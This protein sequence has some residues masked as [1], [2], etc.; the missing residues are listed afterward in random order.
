MRVCWLWVSATIAT[1]GCG[2]PVRP[3][4]VVVSIEPS[5]AEVPH[6]PP[7]RTSCISTEASE[8]LT[9][10]SPR[11][12]TP[13]RR[14]A[15]GQRARLAALGSLRQGSGLKTSGAAG[16]VG[17][18]LRQA[19]TG[20]A[21]LAQSGFKIP[22]MVELQKLSRAYHDAQK[23]S[24]SLRDKRR[25][26]NETVALLLGA[27]TDWHLEAAGLGGIRG[28][29]DPKT[30]TLSE[31]L[32]ASV[33]DGFTAQQLAELSFPGVAQK[34]WPTLA[35]ARY[36][37][38]DL[39][40]FQKKW[41]QCAGAFDAVASAEPQ[42]ALIAD[43][44]AGAVICYQNVYAVKHKDGSHRQGLRHRIGADYERRPLTDEQQGTVR[45]FARHICQFPPTKGDSEAYEIYTEVKYARAR[46]YLE[47][48]HWQQAAEAFRDVAFNHADMD[49]GIYAARLYL[50]SLLV[51]ATKINSP[52]TSC[53]TTI[54]DDAPKLLE[55]YCEGTRLEENEEQCT[56][57][58]RI[59]SH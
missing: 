44:E 20:K 13:S 18:C 47:A 24:Q 35:Q 21:A 11:Q 56:V 36:A 37:K 26:A 14:L 15:V 38:G 29:G 33:L 10:C 58:K 12:G 53:Q 32:Y 3:N 54:A 46:T 1:A 52:R 16:L 6:D 28:T 5:P 40:H 4:D 31:T 30:L 19:D 7:S 42:G 59:R 27:A 50:E 17:A 45:S 34:D 9:V 48:Q 2:A 25:C 57:M 51:M 49:A 22:A 43:A 39:L 55:L 41:S 8:A 23:G